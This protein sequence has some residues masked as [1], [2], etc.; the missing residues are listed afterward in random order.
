VAR[1]G[2]SCE[3]SDARIDVV[4]LRTRLPPAYRL[5]AHQF[6]RSVIHGARLRYP[7]HWGIRRDPV[8]QCVAGRGLGG[9]LAYGDALEIYEAREHPLVPDLVL[10]S[11]ANLCS[12]DADV[13][14]KQRAARSGASL[15]AENC[16]PC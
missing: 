2:R 8:P 10:G 4:G 13:V 3:P 6:G 12:S 15:V 11:T 1:I 14:A 9:L 5:F 7:S 16:Q